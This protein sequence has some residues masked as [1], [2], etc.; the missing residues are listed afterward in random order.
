ME[1]QTCGHLHAVSGASIVGGSGLQRG[2]SLEEQRLPKPRA[3]SGPRSAPNISVVPSSEPQTVLRPLSH[4]HDNSTSSCT[5]R[6]LGRWRRLAEPS[7]TPSPGPWFYRWGLQSPQPDPR[8][9]S[10]A[11][12][13][14]GSPG[15]QQMLCPFHST[16]KRICYIVLQ[17]IYCIECLLHTRPCS[18][19]CEYNSENKYLFSWRETGKKLTR[20]ISVVC[21]IAASVLE[22]KGRWDRREGAS[23]LY[24]RDGQGRTGESE[25][26]GQEAI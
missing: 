22:N 19:H 10:Q 5:T 12:A 3:P 21:Q 25:G 15:P 20:S 17:C 9:P 18:R 7:E 13:G 11:M 26:V 8:S 1:E 6:L 4:P 14:L 2:P 23:F 24:Y 16:N